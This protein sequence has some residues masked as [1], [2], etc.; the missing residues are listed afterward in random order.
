MIIVVNMLPYLHLK[1]AGF[2]VVLQDF[3]TGKS[4]DLQSIFYFYVKLLNRMMLI[5]LK[6]SPSHISHTN[7]ALWF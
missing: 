1:Y 4:T 3:K 6:W 5:S 2:R 7:S